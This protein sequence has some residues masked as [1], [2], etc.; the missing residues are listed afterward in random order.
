MAFL[1]HAYLQNGKP[2][3]AA[4]ILTALDFAQPNQSQTLAAL[5]AAQ[6]R[7]NK[8]ER[9]LET[10]DRLAMS[11]RIDAAFHLLRGQALSALGR[12]DEASLAMQTYLQMR[13]SASPGMSKD[14]G[15][16][17]KPPTT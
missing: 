11:G 17:A 8:A 4:V 16:R 7:S 6:I 1:A 2:D 12:K 15:I 13:A 10:L 14:L 3:K 9:A 5:A